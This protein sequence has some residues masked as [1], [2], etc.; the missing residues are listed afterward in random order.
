[1]LLVAGLFTGNLMAQE[2]IEGGLWIGTSYNEITGL[3]PL[4]REIGNQ[5]SRAIGV[6]FPV[7]CKPRTFVFNVGAFVSYNILPWLSIKGGV[8]F[9]PKGECLGGEAYLSTN[10]NMESE[11]LVQNTWLK[12]AYLEAPLSVQFSTRSKKKPGAGFLY[13]DL[14]YSPSFLMSAKMDITTSYEVRGFNKA[15][16]TSKTIDS[17]HDVKDLEGVRKNDPN[18]FASL[19]YCFH[20]VYIELKASESLDDIFSDSDGM[21]ALNN[22]YA[23][24][25]GFHF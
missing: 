4:A 24:K 13:L 23:V 21:V 10:L 11:V 8:E 6:E 9:N 18:I 5:L 19:G 14:G 7:S 20:K 16:V 25:L 1:M 17:Q 2:K 3:E 22:M 15:G 12:L